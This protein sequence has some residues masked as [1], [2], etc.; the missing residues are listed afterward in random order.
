MKLDISKEW[1]TKMAKLEGDHEIGAGALP[2]IC[3]RHVKRGTTYRILHDARFQA[4][5]SCHDMERVVVY[6][7]IEDGSVWVR[8]YDEFMDGRFQPIPAP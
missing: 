8:P 4:Y 6:Q 5:E 2:P 7:C 3:Y 1:I